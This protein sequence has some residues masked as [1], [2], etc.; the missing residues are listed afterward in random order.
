MG[1]KLITVDKRFRY[2][3]AA[4]IIEGGDILFAKNERDSYYYSVGGAVKIGESAEDAVRREV[5]E[6]TG[7]AYEVERLAFIHENFFEGKGGTLKKGVKC[8]EVCFYYLM[9]SR[10]TRELKSDSFATDGIR[11]FMKWLPIEKLETY[12]AHPKFFIKELQ[13]IGEHVKHI[14]TKE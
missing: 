1:C 3:A 2:R 5:L 8:H 9:K 7:I 10:G 12:E 14:T 6:E 4:I 11:E 13:S